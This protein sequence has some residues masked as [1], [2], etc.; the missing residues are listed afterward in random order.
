MQDNGGGKGERPVVFRR[1]PGGVQSASRGFNL[2]GFGWAEPGFAIGFRLVFRRR[3]AR[4]I[5]MGREVGEG[6]HLKT[7]R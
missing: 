5:L 7:A 3:V 2:R 4:R 6:V 1:P